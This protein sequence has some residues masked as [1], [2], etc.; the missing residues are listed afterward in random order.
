MPQAGG[1]RRGGTAT[2]GPDDAHLVNLLGAFVSSLGD[3]LAVALSDDAH[4]GTHSIAVL[5]VGTWPGCSIDFLARVVGLTHSGTVRLVDRL[6]STGTLQRGAGG[7][8]RTS[9]LRLTPSGETLAQR[10]KERRS[11]VLSQALAQADS[12]E[13][14]VL[15]RVLD[16]ALRARPRSL[17]EARR[18]CR[19]CD[20]S[21]CVGDDCPI[22]SSVDE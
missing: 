21:V 17:M 15:S 6:E 3:Q 19:L 13:R 14:M 8:G 22:G 9:A 10:L 16:R 12:T 5:A 7:D 20:H 2:A 18:E 11:V 1:A 4:G